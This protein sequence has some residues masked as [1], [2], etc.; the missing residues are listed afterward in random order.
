MK[1]GIRKPNIKK[2]IKART[3]GK[4]KR[5]VKKSINPFYGKRGAGFVKNPVK[6]VK[7]SVY[8]K[9]TVGVSDI[10]RAAVGSSTAAASGS[11]FIPAAHA[12]TVPPAADKPQKKKGG[13]IVGGGFCLFVGVVGLPSSVVGGLMFIAIGAALLYIGI[14]KRKQGAKVS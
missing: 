7:N 9:T 11:S 5:A 1:I 3:T 10:A 13:F 6:S 14:K 8:H 4:I 2:S 12:P